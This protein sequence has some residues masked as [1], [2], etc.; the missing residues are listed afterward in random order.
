MIRNLI[1]YIV[2][3]VYGIILS[4]LY[5]DY[6]IFILT[7]ALCLLPIVSFILTLIASC[8]LKFSFENESVR[9]EKGESYPLSV[10]V[11]NNSFFPI[12]KCKFYLI[13]NYGG[14]KTKIKRKI[15]FS[16]SSRTK[17][18]LEVRICPEYCG[19]IQIQIAKIRIYDYFKIFKLS[20]RAANSFEAVIYP[21]LQFYFL[22][23]KHSN[24]LV[25]GESEEFSDKRPGDDPS[26]VFQIRDYQ[27]GDRLQR[28]H[29]KLSSKKKTLM[30]KDFSEPVITETLVLFDLYCSNEGAKM[31]DELDSLME[32]VLSVSYSLI[33]QGHRHYVSW[34]DAAIDQI[35]RRTIYKEED[36]Y[37]L[38]E[39]IVKSKTYQAKGVFAKNYA[40]LF[41]S[42]KMTNVFY[43]GKDNVESFEMFG[44]KPEVVSKIE[45]QS[46]D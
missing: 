2:F 40:A 18:K 19:K 46:V 41:P 1:L 7:I 44:L 23:V 43:V 16:I 17:Q 11:D 15:K 21:K 29:W 45:K 3:S 38:M 36:F 9:I 42:E 8:S 32:Q 24:Y 4:V 5:T 12:G 14:Q 6:V 25:R 13:C 35:I 27:Q 37:F 34:Y 33:T 20:K 10:L 39:E 22:E 26:E 31:M 28:I 30:V